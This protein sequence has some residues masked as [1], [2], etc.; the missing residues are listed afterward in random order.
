MDKLQA[1]W[2][3]ILFGGTILLSFL[4]GNKTLGLSACAILVLRLVGATG[5]LTLLAD[6][7]INW[8]IFLLTLAV[9]APLA[10]NRYDFSQLQAVIHSPAG[11]IAILAGILVTLL[12]SRGVTASTTDLT[13]LLGVTLGS[14]AGVVLFR[15]TPMGP[16]IGSGIAAVGIT[17]AR[18]IFKF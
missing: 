18:A 1:Y 2:V 7:G 13:I 11:W 8:G 4:I 15:G 3:E 5:V 12:G 9:F 14:V 17:A 6:K 16:L 10:L